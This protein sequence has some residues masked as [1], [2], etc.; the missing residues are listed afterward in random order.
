MQTTMKRIPRGLKINLFLQKALIYL[1][2]TLLSVLFLFWMYILVVN[3]TRQSSHIQA[4]FSIQFGDNFYNN[5]SKM[6]NNSNLKVFQAIQ[7]SFFIAISSAILSTYF[8]AMTAYGIHMYH[9]KWRKAAFV[10]IM[11]VMIIPSQVATIG[12]LSLL[13]QINFVDNYLVL[14]VPSIA[15]P[16]VFF[17][18]KQY[19]DSVLPYEIIE[20]ARIDGAGELRIFH[21]IVL[22]MIKPALAV[23]F[24]FSFVGSWNAFF[25]PAM[26]ITSTNKRTIPLI[27]AELRQISNPEN[28]DMGLVYI[29]ICFAVL[30][31]V[32]IYFIFSKHIIK[33][34]TLGSI[35]G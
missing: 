17:F 19:L 28:F 1:F 2:L 5:F 23:Q 3:A 35:K 10:F 29:I 25:F 31:L 9:F 12:L 34:V 14:I 11:F 32:I 18:I 8:S 26:V 30:P 27:I 16:A 20:S 13:Y 22:P 15:A 24:I 4:S 21:Q 6:V 33:G 7:N